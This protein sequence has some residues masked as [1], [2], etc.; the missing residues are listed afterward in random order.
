MK[1]EQDYF[2]VLR[3]VQKNQ[4][5]HKESLLKVWALVWVN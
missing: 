2:E 5:L 1:K 3:S 4:A